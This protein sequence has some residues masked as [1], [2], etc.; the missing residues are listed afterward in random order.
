MEKV[1]ENIERFLILAEQFYK[2]NILIYIK[3]LYENFYMG[4]IISFDKDKI[5]IECFAPS[6]KLNKSFNIYWA[7][8]IKF[9]EY[10]RNRL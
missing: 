9:V 7:N 8:I 3:D 5:N 1:K 10:R 6:D 4:K 2:E